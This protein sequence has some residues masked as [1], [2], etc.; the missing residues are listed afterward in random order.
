MVTVVG[1]GFAGVEAAWA[2]ARRGAQVR[3]VEM[4]PVRMTPAH[5]TPLLCELVCS[6][7]FKSKLATTPAGRLKQEMVALGSLVIPT[8]E[9][10]AVPGGEALCVD[11]DRYA[12]AITSA[13]GSHPAIEVVRTEFDGILVEQALR[14]GPVI[15]ATGPLTS[16]GLSAYL[17]ELAGREHLYFY[18]AVSPVVDAT[19]LD[20]SVIFAQSRYDKG[21]DDYLNCPFDQESYARF[22]QELVTAERAPIHDFEAED[23]EHKVVDPR[24]RE[25]RFLE[26]IKY[27][28]GCT[29]IEA[30]ADKGA[31]SLAFGNFK[32]VGLR[33]PR[34]GR[35]PYAALQLRPEN[36]ERSLFSLVAC[37]TRLKWGEQKRV[38]RLVPGLENAEFVR[39]GVI[40]RNTYLEAPNV[41]TE[42]LEMRAR[43]GLFVAGQLTGVEGY[44]ESAAMGIL[45]G[46]HAAAVE[47]GERVGP[48]PRASAYGSLLAH[49]QDRTEREFAPMNINWGLFQEPEPPI[50]DRGR[51]QEVKLAAAE[52]AFTAWL[53]E[54][55]GFAV[56]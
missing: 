31:R 52:A 27:F 4:R 5:K 3:L 55:L 33:D 39:F 44:V 35:R 34:T 46:I 11:R 40:H 41:L 43:R 22:V 8:G 50:K 16:A 1:G 48:P 6:N 26:Q 37:Q 30:I 45:A 19:T 23:D 28:S 47:R 24:L 42:R 51:R 29:P 25:E 9:A 49:L 20:R 7:S 54:A 10:H 12:E 56:R 32:P 14:D 15:L 13:I 18:D 17:A 2:A 36:R 53:P 21:G 38:F